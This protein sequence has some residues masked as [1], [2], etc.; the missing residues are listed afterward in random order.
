MDY[1]NDRFKDHSLM[2]FKDDKLIALLPANIVD[3]NLRSHQGLT[4]GGFLL[5]D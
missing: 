1:H 2:V 5:Q 3:F 4:Y